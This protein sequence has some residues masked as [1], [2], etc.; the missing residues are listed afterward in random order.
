MHRIRM[1]NDEFI[2]YVRKNHDCRLTNEPLGRQ[3]WIWI[4][5]NANGRKTEEDQPC[6]WGD[7][8]AHIGEYR[9]PK[10]ATQFEF[11][12]AALPDLYAFLEQ[13]ARENPVTP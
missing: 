7:T 13:V 10:T 3:I 8:G 9:L 6:R 5:E 1:G 12:A 11:D 2:L 4:R